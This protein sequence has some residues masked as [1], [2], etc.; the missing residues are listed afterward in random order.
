MSAVAWIILLVLILP[1]I[2][3]L[4]WAVLRSSF[5]RVPSGSMG[6]LLVKG[7]ATDRSVLPGAHFVPALRRH[8]VELY[9]SVE[10]TF[11]ADG[12][13][14]DS[15]LTASAPPLTVTLGDR[16]TVTVSVTVR[17]RLMPD[18]LRL[19]HE[20]FGPQGLF[21]IVRD[22]TN[23]AV[24]RGL[25]E[26]DIGVKDLLGA[27]RETT[28]STVAQTVAEA[29]RRDGID[30]TA[31]TLGSVDLGRTGEVVQAISRA[32]YELE[33]EEVEA[34]TRL[35]RA[36]NDAELHRL[37]EPGTE[38]AWRYRNPDLL[39]DLAPR[40]VNFSLSVAAERTDGPAQPGSA[41]SGS[42]QT[43]SAAPAPGPD[44]SAL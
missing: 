28:E 38:A 11:R 22:E 24:Q 36:R 17:F 7:R 39:R 12:G 9:P 41:Q 37:L 2:G 30:L 33:R 3:L 16:T 21:T 19:V 26:P 14:D 15:P 35:A 23:R 4:I 43:D 18:Q 5:V 40:A 42:A 13:V 20:R 25:G 29:L 8:M 10:L 32:S 31:F 1:M 44:S 34:R 6:L 27:S